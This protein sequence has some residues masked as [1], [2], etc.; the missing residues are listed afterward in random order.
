MDTS[1]YTIHNY[2]VISVFVS[3][4]RLAPPV[5]SVCAAMHVP[6]FTAA[7]MDGEDGG[8]RFLVR[9]GPTRWQVQAAIRDLVTDEQGLNWKQVAVI[10][11]RETGEAYSANVS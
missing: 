4:S 2:R 9:L 6:L 7:P 11:H 5:S 10:R 1:V 3:S 8:S